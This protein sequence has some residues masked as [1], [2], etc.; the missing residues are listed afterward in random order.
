MIL[1]V[2]RVR[3]RPGAAEDFAALVAEVRRAAL[4]VDGVLCYEFGASPRD[5][6]RFAVVEAYRDEAARQRHLSAPGF[7]AVL[8]AARALALEMASEQYLSPGG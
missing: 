2:T 5:P 3:V 7:A 4:A 1:F 6:C 8:D